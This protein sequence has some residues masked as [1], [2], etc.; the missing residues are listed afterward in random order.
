[1]NPEKPLSLQHWVDSFTT[2]AVPFGLYKSFMPKPPLVVTWPAEGINPLY[3]TKYTDKVLSQMNK[4][5]YHGFPRLV[6][7]L[8]DMSHVS[9]SIGGD[10]ISYIHVRI[11]GAINTGGKWVEG[12]FEYIISPDGMINHRFFKWK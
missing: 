11:P 4:D 6:D 2:V 7:T 8:A 5:V 9:T 10:G 12:F 1:M 3:G